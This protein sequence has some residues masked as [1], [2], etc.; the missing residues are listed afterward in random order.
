[1]ALAESRARLAAY[2]THYGISVTTNADLIELMLRI[3]LLER[4]GADGQIWWRIAD[5][6]PLPGERLPLS[7]AEISTEDSIRW[8]RVHYENSQAIIALFV[9][10]DLDV[11]ST[12][13]AGLGERLELP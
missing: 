13:L 10:D 2:A 7:E 6:L 9:R 11:L 12:S 3:G 5:P 4:V 8:H 1:M